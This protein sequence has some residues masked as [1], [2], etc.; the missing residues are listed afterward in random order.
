MGRDGSRPARHGVNAPFIPA[1]PAPDGMPREP[2]PPIL[3]VHRV[4][5]LVARELVEGFRLSA[6]RAAARLGIAP[7][8]ISQYLSG[9]RM[10]AELAARP[11]RPDEERLIRQAAQELST[12]PEPKRP[13]STVILEVALKCAALEERSPAPGAGSLDRPRESMLRRRLRAR[14][15]AEQRAVADC[16]GLAQKSRDELTRSVFRQIASDS[17][18][19]AEIAASIESRLARGINRTAPSGVRRA[20]VDRLI[21]RERRAEAAAGAGLGADLG[22]VMRLLWE[23]MEADERKHDALL[24]QLRTLESGPGARAAH[25]PSRGSGRASTR[26]R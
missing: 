25:R 13:A 8:A 24:Q 22:G 16:M 10:K 6:R 23:S 19:H 7:S 9:R 11:G 17:L 12:T 21:A 4:Q 3:W 18:R 26:P 14:I 5:A 15:R 1:R 20:D 2:R